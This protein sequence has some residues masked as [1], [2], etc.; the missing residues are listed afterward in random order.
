M[1]KSEFPDPFEKIRKEKGLGYMNDQDD[2]VQMVLRFRDLRKY[3]H[4]WKTFSSERGEVGRVV[5]P[6]EVP[7]RD[8]RQ[9]P[10]EVDPP[11][12]TE[13]RK[14]VADWFRR[15]MQAEYQAK[16]KKIIDEMVDT[17]LDGKEIDIVNDFALPIQSRALTVLLNTEYEESDVWIGWGTHVFR[18]EGE[19]LDADKAAF[20]Y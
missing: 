20:L 16:L 8:T 6:S 12:H 19:A 17:V 4:D 5:V 7:I 11:K 15:P 3:A 18:S 13:Y 10:F 1:K 14:L 2:P 9:I